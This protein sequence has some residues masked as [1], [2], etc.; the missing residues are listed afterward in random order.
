ML[1]EAD[2][3]RI[4][5]GQ[6]TDGD[7]ARL[8]AEIRRQRRLNTM[9]VAEAEY[10]DGVVRRASMKLYLEAVRVIHNLRRQHA[11]HDQRQQS[12][13]ATVQHP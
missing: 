2:L 12:G 6:Y 8:A 7:V 3:R 9:L 10:W 11:E 5:A 13:G 4:E 1:Q